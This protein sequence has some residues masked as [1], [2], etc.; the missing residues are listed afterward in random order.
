LQ[1]IKKHQSRRRRKTTETLSEN[2]FRLPQYALKKLT[3][4]KP[5]DEK[6]KYKREKTSTAHH[7][8]FNPMKFARNRS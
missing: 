2:F 7:V 5:G 4:K 3:T 6:P 8:S 1:A